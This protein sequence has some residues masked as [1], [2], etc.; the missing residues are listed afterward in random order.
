ML[1]RDLDV[2]GDWIFG[3]GFSN[4]ATQNNAIALNI[5]TRL[6]S[7]VGDCFFD[8]KAGID[9]YNRLGS[10]NQAGLLDLDLRRVTLQ[11]EGVTGLTQFDII[12]QN[13][14]FTGNYTVDTIY[15]QDYTDTIKLEI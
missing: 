7:W 6:L 14:N 9:W 1:F 2:D 12:N 3:A 11:T 8:M 5:K 13:R 10:K 4:L 15:G